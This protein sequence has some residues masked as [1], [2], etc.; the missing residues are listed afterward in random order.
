MYTILSGERKLIEI[1]IASYF[2]SIYI[3]NR[4]SFFIYKDDIK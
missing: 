1:V 3:L 2:R 4:I